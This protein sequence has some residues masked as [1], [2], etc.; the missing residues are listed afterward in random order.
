MSLFGQGRTFLAALPSQDRRALFSRGTP[1]AYAPGETVVREGES[2][3]FVV[4]ILSG[5]SVVS[6]ETERGTRLI[7]ALRGA[8][9][10]VGDLAAVDQRPRSATVTAL[11]RLETVV[12][13]GRQFRGFL[14]SRPAATSLIMRQL[15]SRLRSADVERRSLASGTV[16]QRL[17]ARLLEL[18][19]RTGRQDGEGIALNLPL[20]QHELAAAVGATREAVAKALRLLREE[21][22]VRTGNRR[23]VVTNVQLLR[24]LAAGQ[25]QPQQP[26][27]RPGPGDSGESPPDV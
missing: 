21:E 2:T 18:A 7:L 16:L 13:P 22:V 24:L 9:E 5:W 10:V 12:V 19:E 27:R 25:S 23:L 20:P 6:V 14:A 8:G 15:S 26:P 4:L 3:T 1:H 11:G 17:A